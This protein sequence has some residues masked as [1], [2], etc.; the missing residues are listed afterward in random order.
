[1]G[2]RLPTGALVVSGSSILIS[3]ERSKRKDMLMPEPTWRNQLDGARP[4]LR[5]ALFYAKGRAVRRPGRRGVSALE[6]DVLTGG[7]FEV[8]PVKRKGRHTVTP[9]EVE[10]VLPP[11]SK[12]KKKSKKPKPVCPKVGSG[13]QKKPRRRPPP[14]FAPPRLPGRAR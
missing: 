9:K 5:R 11:W 4:I 1:M 3:N 6:V 7:G 14:G 2:I 12:T 13:Q 8:Q 10:E